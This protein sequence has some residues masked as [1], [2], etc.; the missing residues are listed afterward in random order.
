MGCCF[1]PSR[2]HKNWK[3]VLWKSLNVFKLLFVHHSFILNSELSTKTHYR[4]SL[5]ERNSALNGDENHEDVGVH[6]HTSHPKAIPEEDQ[7]P[8]DC[9]DSSDCSSNAI[10]I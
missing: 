10:F 5:S 4:T 3:V 1:R 2:F 6:A 9:S 7:H 8:T